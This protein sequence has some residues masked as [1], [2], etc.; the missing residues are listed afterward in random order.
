MTFAVVIDVTGGYA[1]VMLAAML[2]LEKVREPVEQSEPH[3]DDGVHARLRA[4]PRTARRCP[5]AHEDVLPLRSAR[6]AAP[7]RRRRP[8]PTSCRR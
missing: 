7:P 2:F 4:W 3:R 1:V 5:V 6:L 8:A